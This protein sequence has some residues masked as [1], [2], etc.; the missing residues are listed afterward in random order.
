M[1]EF[2]ERIDE[3]DIAEK[4]EFALRGKGAFGRFKDVVWADPDLKRE[5][6]EHRKAGFLEIA[7]RWF[8]EIDLEPELKF[9]PR[10]DGGRSPAPA[11]P[12]A[13]RIRLRDLLLLGAPDGKTE[14][15]DGR[16]YRVLR[17]QSATEARQIFKSVAR[18]L[19][20]SEGIAWRNRFIEGRNA[21]EVGDYELKVEGALITLSVK[22]SM[23]VWRRFTP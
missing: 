9:R 2:A 18:E 15:L 23:D 7:R 13:P 14:L 20:E 6:F 19:Y 11:A 8:E 10:D 17:T 1:A 22:T 16:V 12:K 4:L 3:P 5:W 21:I